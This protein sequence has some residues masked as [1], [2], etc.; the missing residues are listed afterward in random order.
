MS[1]CCGPPERDSRAGA[2]AAP[3]VVVLTGCCGVVVSCFS[4]SRMSAPSPRPNAFLG[5][6]DD[7]L[8][9]LGITLRPLAVYIIE[10]NRFTKAW[11]FRQPHV[12]RNHG[13]ED[14]RSEKAAKICGDLAR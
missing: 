6:A 12:A 14:L 13:L 1:I 9:E 4:G 11:R 10:N 3:C 2:A 5:I 7:L 8:G